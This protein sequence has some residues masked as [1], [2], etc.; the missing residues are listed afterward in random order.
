MTGGLE[1]S[2]TMRG[3]LISFVTVD[4]DK[5][6]LRYS[7]GEPGREDVGDRESC[8]D[9]VLGLRVPHGRFQSSSELVKG[10]SKPGQNSDQARNMARVGGMPPSVTLFSWALGDTIMLA[11]KTPPT[12]TQGGVAISRGQGWELGEVRLHRPWGLWR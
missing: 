1:L 5:T 6:L 12:A 11:P 3:D 2:S 10:W 4:G 9:M 7:V 8:R